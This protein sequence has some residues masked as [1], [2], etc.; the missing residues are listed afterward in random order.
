MRGDPASTK[1]KEKST[2]TLIE[3][4]YQTTT[5]IE[6]LYQDLITPKQISDRTNST[7]AREEEILIPNETEPPIHHDSSGGDSVITLP[8]QWK[9]SRMRRKDLNKTRSNARRNRETHHATQPTQPKDG[10]L[11]IHININCIQERKLSPIT[12]T[13][14]ETAAIKA[15]DSIGWDHFIR[16]RD[17]FQ[18]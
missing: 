15:Q 7:R 5:L 9:R 17:V 12:L 1:P 2:T 8:E 18:V 14:L 13:P 11:P 16:G 6:P 10:K 4:L 3:P